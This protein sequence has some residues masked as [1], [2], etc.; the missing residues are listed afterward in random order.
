M[1]R[2]KINYYDLIGN[3][4][5]EYKTFRNFTEQF[6]KN[7]PTIKCAIDNGIVKIG[8]LVLLSDHFMIFNGIGEENSKKVYI[9]KD[10]L[11]WYYGGIKKEDPLHTNC[12]YSHGLVKAFEDSSLINT[13]DCDET[14]VGKLLFE[15]N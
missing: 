6:L 3:I 5:V 9:F 14:K 1:C 15:N 10:S 8:D 7:E 2:Q 11:S 12:V 4:D 13:K